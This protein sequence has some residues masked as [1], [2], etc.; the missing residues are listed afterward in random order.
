MNEWDFRRGA[1]AE[2]KKEASALDQQF[3]N[4]RPSMLRNL[5]MSTPSA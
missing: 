5:G 4:Y 3:T 2:D 1:S